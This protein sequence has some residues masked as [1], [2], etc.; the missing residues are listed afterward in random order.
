MR[1]DLSPDRLRPVGARRRQS[2][3]R[4]KPTLLAP[5]LSGGSCSHGWNIGPSQSPEAK[6]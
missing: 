1:L 6:R 3:P 5:A 4:R 2:L